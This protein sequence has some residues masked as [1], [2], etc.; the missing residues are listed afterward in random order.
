MKH[1]H[2]EES[3]ILSKPWPPRTYYLGTGA[4]KGPLR[5][6][7]LGTWGA[8]EGITF[9]ALGSTRHSGA[10]NPLGRNLKPHGDRIR[11]MGLER[12]VVPLSGPLLD[13]VSDIGSISYLPELPFVVP[14]GASVP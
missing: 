4:F 8:R 12:S 13:L 11:C 5:T 7:Y 1:E 6:Y 2:D 14:F 9:M 10:G 3:G